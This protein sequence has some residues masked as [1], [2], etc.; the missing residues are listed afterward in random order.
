MQRVFLVHRLS[1][2]SEASSP[3][4]LSRWTGLVKDRP[5]A[6]LENAAVIWRPVRFEKNSIMVPL[7]Q[8]LRCVRALCIVYLRKTDLS[9]VLAAV[10]D[11]SVTW[12]T[13]RILLL[14]KWRPLIV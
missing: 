3:G 1:V 8:W 4:M 9:C 10:G 2:L 6:H 7:K 11:P 13:L 14:L 5:R 12:A